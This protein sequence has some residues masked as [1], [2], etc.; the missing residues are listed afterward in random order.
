MYMAQIH[1]CLEFMLLLQSNFPCPTDHMNM[2][3]SNAFKQFVSEESP[4]RNHLDLH[5]NT[6]YNLTAPAPVFIINGM[7][8]E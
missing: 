2:L 7:S 8:K 3:F 1:I 6:I 4:I 5:K